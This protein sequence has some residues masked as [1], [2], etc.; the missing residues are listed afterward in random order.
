MQAPAEIG[1]QEAAQTEA[2]GVEESRISAFLTRLAPF[3]EEIAQIEELL[4]RLSDRV[5]PE[6]GFE[7]MPIEGWVER[8]S[9]LEIDIDAEL[10]QIALFLASA[11]A[12]AAELRS[13]S[14]RTSE[15]STSEEEWEKEQ[16][17][18]DPPV[19][20]NS[21]V[22]ALHFFNKT[23][24]QIRKITACHHSLSA[25]IPTIKARGEMMD[26]SFR[27][28]SS[29]EIQEVIEEVKLMLLSLHRPY[30]HPDSCTCHSLSDS[31]SST[32]FKSA[33]SAQFSKFFRPV[34]PVL[35]PRVSINTYVDAA[36]RL[37]S[38]QEYAGAV[39]Q[40]ISA[41]YVFSHLP[42]MAP[43][44]WLLIYGRRGVPEDYPR[45]AELAAE[46][47]VKGCIHCAGVLSLCLQKGW[48]V[49]RDVERAWQLARTS[50]AAGS[51]Y[52]Q[53][54]LGTLT[55]YDESEVL[56]AETRAQY[57]LSVAQGLDAA[58]YGLGFHYSFFDGDNEEALRLYRLAAAQ[59]F[60]TAITMEVL[61]SKLVLFAA[62]KDVNKLLRSFL[63][64]GDRV[65]QFCMLQDEFLKARELPEPQTHLSGIKQTK[66]VDEVDGRL[67][68]F[69]KTDEE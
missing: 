31:P 24:G 60:E 66:Q 22:A 19:L 52:G 64:G 20:P 56:R 28:N 65:K 8:Y 32:G 50:A 36:A 33:S 6:T 61:I 29:E 4:L 23:R 55:F 34:S 45:A 37:Y 58:Q 40:Y 59:G 53:F 43:L 48:G 21:I 49:A 5:L 17:E 1:L 63:A 47:N 16:E 62:G 41:I 57:Q 10:R 38:T 7:E 35:R 42:S 39:V 18:F 3:S 2:A 9:Q 30:R 51:R 27:G 11:T 14:P 12:S 69:R 15:K 44:A 54:A 25:L 46:G 26:T 67:C 68:K 13:L